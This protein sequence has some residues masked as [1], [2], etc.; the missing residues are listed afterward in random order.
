M[1]RRPPRSTRTDTLFPFTT[2]FR[3]PISIGV[4]LATALSVHE[5]IIGA[6]H[7]YFDSAVMLL[8]FLLAGRALDASMRGRTRAGI[9]AL[10]TSMGRSA[11]VIRPDGA[12]ER[13]AADRLE[14]GM[15]MLVAAG[16]AQIGRAT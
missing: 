8:F 14:P 6:E 5:T 2:L 4:I 16:E 9:G 12:T 1:I 7:A 11:S 13:V 10:L 15:M 3:S